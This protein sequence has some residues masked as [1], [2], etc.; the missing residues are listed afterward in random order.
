MDQAREFL[1][2]NIDANVVDNSSRALEALVKAAEEKPSFICLWRLMGDA[3]TLL[4][5]ISEELIV[6]F[7]VPQRLHKVHELFVD[8]RSFR[9]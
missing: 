9:Q 8:R 3:L 1:E 6:P 7:K 5:P 4:E 2:D